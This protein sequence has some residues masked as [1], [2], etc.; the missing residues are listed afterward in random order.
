MS[1]SQTH[2]RPRSEYLQDLDVYPPSPSSPPPSKIADAQPALELP[3]IVSTDYPRLRTILRDL[4]VVPFKGIFD[5]R[6]VARICG[7]SDKTIR[8]WTRRGLIPCCYWPLGDPYYTARN[9]EDFF[10]LCERGRRAA[11]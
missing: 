3:A 10:A 4:N 7:K 1:N 6:E 8:N 9:L 11:K 5:Q 2:K